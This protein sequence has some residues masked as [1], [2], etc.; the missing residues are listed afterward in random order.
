MIVKIGTVATAGEHSQR[1]PTPV[2][3]GGRAMWK[4]ENET[5]NILNWNLTPK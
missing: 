3:Q 1:A 2:T 4:I 5:C